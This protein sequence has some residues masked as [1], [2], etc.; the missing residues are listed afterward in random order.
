VADIKGIGPTPE[1]AMTTAR[2]VSAAFKQQLKE[3]QAV[4]GVDPRF[5]IDVRTVETPNDARLR[6]SDKLRALVGVVGLGA[7]VLFVL[8]SIAEAVATARA[9]RTRRVQPNANP[10]WAIPDRVDES[11]VAMS[12][13]V[14]EST[15]GNGS[16]HHAKHR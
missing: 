3:L 8:V 1:I 10:A 5:F 12:A 4:E 11:S 6:A 2:L 16:G 14:L 9:E 15:N 13:P 7:F